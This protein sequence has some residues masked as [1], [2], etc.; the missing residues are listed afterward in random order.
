[1]QA[2][3]NALARL[4]NNELCEALTDS[5]WHEVKWSTERQCFFFVEDFGER[6]CRADSIIEWVPGSVKF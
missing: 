6:I 1:M 3:S 2:E 4:M 5:G